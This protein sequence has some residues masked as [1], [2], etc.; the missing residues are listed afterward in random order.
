MKELEGKKLL[1]L[2][3]SKAEV[4]VVLY[5]IVFVHSVGFGIA[6]PQQTGNARALQA[7]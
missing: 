2:G 6:Y 3:K 5:H 1:I 4:D 7:G